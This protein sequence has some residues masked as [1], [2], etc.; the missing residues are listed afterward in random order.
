MA[1]LSALKSRLPRARIY[2]VGP[3]L[4]PASSPTAIAGVTRAVSSAA[5]QIGVQGLFDPVAERWIADGNYDSD[6]LNLNDTGHAEF[7]AG[8]VRD[9][10]AIGEQ[11]GAG[12][13]DPL[14]STG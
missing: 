8:L 13:A 11:R 10:R 4:P 9:L 14:P 3:A 5:K 1:L 12:C 6:R 7:A 2:V